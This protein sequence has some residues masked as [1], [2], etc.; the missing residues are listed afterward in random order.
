MGKITHRIPRTS[1]PQRVAGIDQGNSL[2]RGLILSVNPALGE[3]FRNLSPTYYGTAAQALNR[4]ERTYFADDSANDAVAFSLP[5]THP[6][7]SIATQCTLS[8]WLD[9]TSSADYCNYFSVP[10][11]AAGWSAPYNAITVY[12]DTGLSN[13]TVFLWAI[14]STTTTSA[15]FSTEIVTGGYANYTFTRDGTTA[16]VYKNGVLVE[17]VAVTNDAVDWGEKRPV[18]LLNSTESSLPNAGFIG[19]HHGLD[20]WNRPLNASEIKRYFDNRWQIVEDIEEES[21]YASGGAA[22]DL[23]GAATATAAAT[24]TLS[25]QIPI[26]GAAATVATATGALSTSIPLLGAAVVTVTASGDLSAQIKLNGAAIAQALAAG[27]IT[28][29]IPLAGAASGTATA[30]GTLDASAAL[31]AAAQAI[32]TAVGSIT[33]QITL[34]G[35]AI[36][37]A[38]ASGALTAPGSGLS[39]AATGQAASTGSLT[40]AIPLIG[41]A[42][43]YATAA[44]GLTTL[45]PLSGAAASV[46]GATG[47]LTISSTL[48][49]AA[50]AQALAGGVLT[51]QVVLSGA[52]V[53]LASAAGVLTG[54]TAIVDST[55][56]VRPK[57]RR[58]SVKPKQRIY[59]GSR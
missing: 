12:K 25:T 41:A 19:H 48:V 21:F 20:V 2:A 52:A 22:A 58:Y 47:D 4:G 57:A 14:N 50:I 34:S 27:G 1:Q 32:A 44:G 40:T 8:F 46:S 6:L 9:V 31:A 51:T 54:G 5:S 55:W 59:K 13:K 11:R 24:G 37:Q 39:G 43:A 53:S 33:T 38:I 30:S 26:V 29:G 7:Y 36:S 18:V 45:I 28:T 56:L 35:A 17:T 15:I 3:T 23:V 16:S 10:W 42:Q 49:G